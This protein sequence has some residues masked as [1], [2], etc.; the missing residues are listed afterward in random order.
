MF[1]G[2]SPHTYRLV[3][4]NTHDARKQTQM[5]ISDTHT[6]TDTRWHLN[7]IQSVRNMVNYMVLDG[8]Q[9][10]GYRLNVWMPERFISLSSLLMPQAYI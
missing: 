2:A 3:Q 1:D 8:T 9:W 4:T 6:L 5:L 10:E 7:T